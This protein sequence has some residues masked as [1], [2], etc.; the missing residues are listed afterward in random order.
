MKMEDVA[1]LAGVSIATVS[2]VIN[3]PERVK[4]E[5][6]EKVEKVLKQTNF[7]ANAVARGL[8]TNSIKT[9]GVL[10][11][12]MRDLF[13]ATATYTIERYFTELGYNVVLCNTG[14]QLGEKKKYIQ[15]LL[16]KKV[17]GLI[18]VGS[19]FRER[20][21]NKHILAASKVVPVVMLNSFLEGDNIYSVL[22]DDLQGIKEAVLYLAKQGYDRNIFY[23]NDVK[24]FSGL[25]KMEGFKKGMVTL[26]WDNT[27]RII[28]IDRSLE[29]GREGVRRLL[30]E[31]KEISAII[32]GEDI[33]AIGAMKELIK[34][35]YRVPEDVGI[36]GYNNSILAETATP[37][38]TSVNNLPE[39]LAKGAVQILYDVLHGKQ[40][41]RK[42]VLSPVLVERESTAR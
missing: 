35:G 9:I 25:A 23:F 18:L 34:A 12:D 37:T 31:K 14:G 33:T 42:T 1:R 4:P 36:I 13:F 39:A 30:K 7:I 16:E 24:S 40:V 28:E 20:T 38:L 10:V 11:V 22:C 32:T 6:R 29:G 19:V 15:I 8:V 21:D 2:R 5:T 26:G 17:D 3:Q 41:A 27:S